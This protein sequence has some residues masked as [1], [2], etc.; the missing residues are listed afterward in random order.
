VTELLEDETIW[1]Y[2]IKSFDRREHTIIQWI[3]WM[4]VIARNAEQRKIKTAVA[5]HTLQTTKLC[6]TVSDSEPVVS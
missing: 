6:E 1:R 2:N 3:W 5:D 4:D